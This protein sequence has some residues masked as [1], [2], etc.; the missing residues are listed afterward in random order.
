[1][2]Q[3]VTKPWANP[4][5]LCA[6]IAATANARA[7]PRTSPPPA[8]PAPGSASSRAYQSAMSRKRTAVTTSFASSVVTV[9]RR[10]TC[11]SGLARDL[12]GLRVCTLDD[13]GWFK[14]EADIFMKS[15]QPWD[16]DQ[17]NVPKHDTYR[18]NLPAWTILP[19]RAVPRRI[20]IDYC[21]ARLGPTSVA[22]P[23]TT[24]TWPVM[25]RA[26]SDSRKRTAPP[27]SQPVPSRLSTEA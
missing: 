19:D 24:R 16:H 22:P 9:A 5:S 12:V 7:V 23:S 14:P 26:C 6:A 21:D 4:S 11:R 25:Y 27:I 3:S 13:P 17:P 18:C 20:V 8:S 15:A 1:M 10:C 2:A